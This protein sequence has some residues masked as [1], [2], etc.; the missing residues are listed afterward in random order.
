MSAKNAVHSNIFL[1]ENYRSGVENDGEILWRSDSGKSSL[2][3]KC[4]SFSSTKMDQ[5]L[6]GGKKLTDGVIVDGRSV[7]KVQ[8]GE[9]WETNGGKYGRNTVSICEKISGILRDKLI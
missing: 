2:S 1:V 6:L 5:K 7:E 9:L 4:T 8:N 3:V